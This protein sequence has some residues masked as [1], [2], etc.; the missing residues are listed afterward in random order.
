MSENDEQQG[1][2]VN[3]PDPRVALPEVTYDNGPSEIEI[4]ASRSDGGAWKKQGYR[5]RVE[6]AT[7]TLV[8]IDTNGAY[9]VPDSERVRNV[10]ARR[11]QALP[12]IDRVI[13]F[14][15]VRRVG[16]ALEYSD[17]D[18]ENVDE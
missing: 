8:T 16:P 15:G 14:D 2:E 10:V 12:F 6:D 4:Q 7:A 11:V 5:F 18:F 9:A 17:D 1:M 3:T 13:L